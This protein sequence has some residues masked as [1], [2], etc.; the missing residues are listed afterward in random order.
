MTTSTARRSARLALCSALVVGGAAAGLVAASGLEA[1]T[2]A[3][4]ALT[5]AEQALAAQLQAEDPDAANRF[6]LQKELQE[7]A[8]LAGLLSQIQQLRHDTAMSVIN[9]IR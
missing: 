5:P 4:P 2:A 9:S 7:R 3:A 8:E 1:G 6:L